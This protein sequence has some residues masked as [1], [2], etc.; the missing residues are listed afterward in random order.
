MRVVPFYHT[1][2][3]LNREDM[4][5]YDYSDSQIVLCREFMNEAEARIALAALDSEGIEAII[6]NEV[7]S[8]IY[9]IGNS[10]LGALRLMVRRHDLEK[11]LDIVNS[12][13]L[14]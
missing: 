4:L 1:S 14:D 7:F 5:K 11:A 12:L 6:D 2:G 13:H 8:R 10:S 3:R 9:P